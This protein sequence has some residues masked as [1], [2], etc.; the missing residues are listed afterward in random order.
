MQRKVRISIR[1]LIAIAA[2]SF[3]AIKVS[4]VGLLSI[5]STVFSSLSSSNL[6]WFG[7]I[8]ALMPL[9]WALEA[10]KWRIALSEFAKIS[11]WRSLRSVWYGVVAGQL[12]PNRIG[13]PIGR[14]ALIDPNSRGKAGVAAVWCS[15]SQQLTTI[16][17]GVIGIAWWLDVKELAVLPSTIPSWFVI[18]II[19]FWVG[20]ILIGIIRFQKIVRWVERF[21][22]VKRIMHGESL[23][24]SFPSTMFIVV[25]S[26]S[27]LRYLIFSTQYV[28]LLWIFGVKASIIDIYAVVALTYLFSSFIPSFSASEV[29]IRAGFAIWFAG[30]IS[31]NALGV[32][33]ASLFLWMLNIALPALIAAW[34]SWKEES[35]R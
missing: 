11:F 21:E 15:F 33:A 4:W 2:Y 23:S 27:M 31:N 26:L 32:T 12:T 5:S 35:D 17:F 22:W 7:L 16:I 1:V 25:L 8:L 34:F 19:F 10:Y 3:I 30:M 24:I 14:L 18:L 6:V 20:L 28:L 9:V 29:G 13:E